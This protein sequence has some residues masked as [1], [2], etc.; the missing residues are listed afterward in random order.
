MNGS[1][2][3]VSTKTNRWKVFALKQVAMYQMFLFF[4]ITKIIYKVYIL[5]TIRF[6]RRCSPYQKNSIGKAL[7]EELHWRS[8]L[9]SFVL[10]VTIGRVIIDNGQV[11][12]QFSCHHEIAGGNGKF[13]RPKK[14][15]CFKFGIFQLEA[16]KRVQK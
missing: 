15:N 3:I 1:E 7:S 14:A 9:K 12:S 10:L 5:Y 6:Y 11:T 8:S 13:W 4:S 16:N 2:S